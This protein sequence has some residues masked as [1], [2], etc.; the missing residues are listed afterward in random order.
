M[1][2][3]ERLSRLLGAMEL[4]ELAPRLERGIPR[5]PTHPHFILDPTMTHAHDGYYCQSLAMPEHL[6]CH[7]DAPAHALADRMDATIDRISARHLMAPAVVY[8]FSS[9]NL[10]AGDLIDAPQ[11]EQ[12]ERQ[13]G[14]SVGA[15]EIA[16]VNYGWLKRHWRTDDEAQWYATNSPGMTEAAVRLFASRRPRAVGADS[17]ACEVSLVNGMAGPNSG[18]MRHWLPQGILIL[19][20]VANLE[21]LPKR[22]YFAA[23]PLPIANGSGSPLR[24]VALF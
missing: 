14:I 10:Q 16:L 23:L 5:W 4:V 22:V 6:G 1:E 13:S 24:P 18:H 19:E 12:M 8:D 15:D 3:V 7:C 11:I 21:K 17:I 20:C 2:N 9:L